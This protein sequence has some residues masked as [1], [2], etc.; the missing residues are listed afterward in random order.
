MMCFY[1]YP[2]TSSFVRE[3]DQEAFSTFYGNFTGRTLKRRGLIG[4]PSTAVVGSTKREAGP[5]ASKDQPRVKVQKTEQPGLE[6]VNVADG[7]SK[8]LSTQ[9]LAS[10]QSLDSE[11]HMNRGHSYH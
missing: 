8:Q 10:D 5:T 1:D 2:G 9:L 7:R 3:E 4:A 11:T 6:G